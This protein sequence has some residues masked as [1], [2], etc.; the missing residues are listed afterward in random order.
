LTQLSTQQASNKK[1]KG[2][3]WGKISKVMAVA[4][5]KFKTQLSA[6]P[7][8]VNLG[9]TNTNTILSRVNMGNTNP[10]TVPSIVNVGNTN[11]KTA[12]LPY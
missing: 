2:K 1:E 6:I 11:P 5:D 4:T 7:R 12:Q 8:I 3:F 9:N 10:N